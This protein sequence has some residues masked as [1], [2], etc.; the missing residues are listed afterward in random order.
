MLT[1]R[2][3]IDTWTNGLHEGFREKVRRDLRDFYC[4]LPAHRLWIYLKRLK[5]LQNG[6]TFLNFFGKIQDS[7]L[8]HQLLF[9]REDAI[10]KGKD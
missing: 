9:G 10:A 1:L 7:K 6:G 3:K 5:F 4:L 2:I 8:R